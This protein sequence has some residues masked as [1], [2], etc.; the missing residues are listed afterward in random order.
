MS[1]P[2]TYK[3]DELKLDIEE[4]NKLLQQASRQKVKDV[5]SIEIRKLQTDLN[6]FHE[7]H[8][9]S[10]IK[11]SDET[12]KSSPKVYEVKLSNYGW[13]QTETTLS[14]YV[15]LEDVEQIPK[16]SV[17]CNFTENSLDLRILGLNNKNYVLTINNLCEDI[18]P[19]KC[20]YKVTKKGLITV[21]LVKKEPQVWLHVTRVEK[22]IKS[23]KSS[24]NPEMGDEGDPGTGIMNLMK[25]MYQEGDDDMK[26]TI[27]KAWADSQEKVSAGL[28]D[29]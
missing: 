11:P 22:K 10:S 7:S 8:E 21:T 2:C 23:L 15:T 3:A 16:E 13:E 20:S 27:A 17:V 18:E 24:L 25:K 28:S 5:L 19:N 12:V 1:T 9:S 6:K 29:F 4:L 26:R 14:L